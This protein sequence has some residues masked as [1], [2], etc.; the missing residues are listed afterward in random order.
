MT[1]TRELLM[2]QLLGNQE[3]QKT[4]VSVRMFP[5]A[6]ILTRRFTLKI[7]YTL[8]SHIRIRIQSY[9]K[10]LTLSH[11]QFTKGHILALIP[12]ISP[13]LTS[14]YLHG[15]KVPYTVSNT[16]EWNPELGRNSSLS[17]KIFN[18]IPFKNFWLKLNYALITKPISGKKKGVTVFHL[19][20]AMISSLELGRYPISPEIHDSQI[21][22]QNLGSIHKIVWNLC[23]IGNQ[24]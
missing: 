5:V 13:L 12:R 14:S 22:D 11:K 24:Q 7:Y 19:K 9:F 1:I 6:I 3:Q 16:T 4:N 2:L 10:A 23:S 15:D 8:T 17:P 20:L 21:H 18:R